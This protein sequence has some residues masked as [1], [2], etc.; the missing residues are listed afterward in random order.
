MVRRHPA[1]SIDVII[2]ASADIHS[3]QREAEKRY[4]R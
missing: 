4:K 3:K 1:R 2:E